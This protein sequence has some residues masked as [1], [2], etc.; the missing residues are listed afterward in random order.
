MRSLRRVREQRPITM[1]LNDVSER[2]VPYSPRAVVVD[3]ATL[4]P[5]RYQIEIE[6]DAGA[7]NVVRAQR[8]V[9]VVE[10]R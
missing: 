1:G 5:G 8:T 3:L 7:G 10:R 9:T 6:L 4:Q 2:G